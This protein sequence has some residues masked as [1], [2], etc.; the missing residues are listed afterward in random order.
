[1]R[2]K[3]PILFPKHQKVLQIL[4]E[5]IKLARKRR[6]LT[7]LQI[8]ERAGLNRNTLTSIEKGS[9]NVSI[10]AYFNVLRAM[11]LQDDFYK[12][13]SDDEFGRKL[14]DLQLLAQT[15]NG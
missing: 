12:L 2:T 13:A 4:G 15:D 11:N 6:G 3:K 9:P 8:A 5:N 7:I 14:Q 10:G 1:M